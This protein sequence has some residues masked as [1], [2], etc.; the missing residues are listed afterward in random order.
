[1]IFYDYAYCLCPSSGRLQDAGRKAES[2]LDRAEVN[3]RSLL[4]TKAEVFAFSKQDEG[5]KRLIWR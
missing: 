2:L 3:P 1:M 5:Q 4:L